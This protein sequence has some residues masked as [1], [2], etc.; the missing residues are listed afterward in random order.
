MDTNKKERK[1]MSER[2]YSPQE[3]TIF[4]KGLIK[5][6]D[7]YYKRWLRILTIAYLQGHI[8]KV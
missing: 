5:T 7:K 2:I 6:D 8:S 3:L 4:D 1:D